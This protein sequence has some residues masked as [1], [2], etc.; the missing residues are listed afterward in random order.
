MIKK[1]RCW[2]QGVKDGNMFSLEIKGQGEL[3]FIAS[4]TPAECAACWA[5]RYPGD[6]GKVAKVSRH[7][8]GRHIGS[9]FVE[10]AGEIEIGSP[11]KDL[12]ELWTR[13]G[14]SKERQD[15]LIAEVTAKA[16][17]GAKVGPWTIGG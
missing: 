9:T 4:E 13:M 6:I 8:P 12:R 3:T 11:E 7:L 10:E 1:G 16:Q 2:A 14:V 15:Q 17:P 5:A